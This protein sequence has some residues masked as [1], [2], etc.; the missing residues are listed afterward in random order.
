MGALNT[1][2]YQM[3]QQNVLDP[4]MIATTTIL[5]CGVKLFEKLRTEYSGML[6][7]TKFGGG[8]RERKLTICRGTA[9][10]L[11]AELDLELTT[12]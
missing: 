12:A 10:R 2:S 3:F 7:Y 6:Y 4:I 1:T 11:S 8:P 9:V 5:T